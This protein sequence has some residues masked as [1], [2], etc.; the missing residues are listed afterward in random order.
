[1]SPFASSP[2]PKMMSR[3]T[4]LPS[5]LL[6]YKKKSHLSTILHQHT[7]DPISRLLTHTNT[8]NACNKCMSHCKHRRKSCHMNNLPHQTLTRASRFFIKNA[9]RNAHKKTRPTPIDPWWSMTRLFFLSKLHS[10]VKCVYPTADV[11]G[12]TMIY[13]RS[14][15]Y[16]KTFPFQLWI[17]RV[18]L[19]IFSSHTQ[20]HAPFQFNAHIWFCLY[21]Y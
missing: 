13:L 9:L 7:S 5:A 15:Y 17:N 6:I 11:F 16:S 20:P 18:W 2:K 19:P 8:H 3:L 12:C 14:E 4:S 1:M 21:K 10:R